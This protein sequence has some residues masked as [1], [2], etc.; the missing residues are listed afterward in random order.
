MPMEKVSASDYTKFIKFKA[1]NLAYAG[2][3][4]PK[5]VQTVAQPVT[6]VSVLNAFI[7]TNALSKT[8]TPDSALGVK[9]PRPCTGDLCVP[10]VPP[11]VKDKAMITSRITP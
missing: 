9:A 2:G 10:Y 6:N 5:A 1:A 8:L 3:I 4:P 7:K 11:Q